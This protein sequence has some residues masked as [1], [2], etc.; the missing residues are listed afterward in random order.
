MASFTE[1]ILWRLIGALVVL[2]LRAPPLVR[3]ALTPLFKKLQRAVDDAR[4]TS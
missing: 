4:R 1:R 3:C 2:D